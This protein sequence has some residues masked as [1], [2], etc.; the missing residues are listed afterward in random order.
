MPSVGFKPTI[1]AG[2]RPK[3]YTLDRM[4]TGTG[5]MLILKHL[6]TLQHVFKCFNINIVDEYIIV[7]RSALIGI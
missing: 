1:S 5:I 4:A 3:T 7:C 6:K 2:E